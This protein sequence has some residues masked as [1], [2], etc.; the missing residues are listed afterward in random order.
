[1]SS[2]APAFYSSVWILMYLDIFITYLPPLFLPFSFFTRA[3]A[4]LSKSN[5][6]LAPQ[7]R[8][9]PPAIFS[10]QK[11]QD[12][13]ASDSFLLVLVSLCLHSV[14]V[15]FW[16]SLNSYSVLCVQSMLYIGLLDVT[17]TSPYILSIY[18]Y[19]TYRSIYCSVCL[20]S[21]CLISIFNV[22]IFESQY[23][24]EQFSIF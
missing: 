4:E 2:W 9:S 3:G 24:F 21:L 22:N 8:S 11:H 14:L 12:P 6:S 5:P 15:S 16:Q 17:Y 1:M 7:K 19:Y 20:S 18:L 13:L 10:V 23:L